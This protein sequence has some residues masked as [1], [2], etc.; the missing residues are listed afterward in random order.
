MGGIGSG[1]WTRWSNQT[2]VESLNRIDMATLKK[3]G[4]VGKV[5]QGSL[6]WKRGKDPA[7]SIRFKSTE[8]SLTLNYNFRSSNTAEWQSVEQRIALEATPCHFGG[9]RYWFVCTGCGARSRVLFINGKYFLCRDCNKLAYSS[10]NERAYDRAIRRH[11]KLK[12]RITDQHG[13]IQRPKG[14]HY[15]TYCR[16]SYSCIVTQSRIN[17][18]FTKMYLSIYDDRLEKWLK[19]NPE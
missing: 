19:A 16:L 13:T 14:M 18:L 11:N 1:Q 8:N 7:V 6:E 3:M 9:T 2:T 12:A 5:K 4:I 10:Q 15:K 17:E